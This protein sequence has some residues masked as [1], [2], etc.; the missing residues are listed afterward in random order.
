MTTTIIQGDLNGK[1]FCLSVDSEAIATI[2]ELFSANF[3]FP[4]T[5]P[6][7]YK[8]P[9]DSL[10]PNPLKGIRNSE[11]PLPGG[12][13]A[14]PG[15]SD[16]GENGDDATGAAAAK[17]QVT[18]DVD[19][20]L[21]VYR[22]LWLKTVSRPSARDTDRRSL[23]RRML[24]NGWT[25]DEL[26]RAI[27]GHRHNTFFLGDNDRATQYRTLKLFIGSADR[28]ERGL[29]LA[30]E[31]Q[32]STYP[33]MDHATVIN[34]LAPMMPAGFDTFAARWHQKNPDAKPVQRRWAL[35][36]SIHRLCDKYG[37]ESVAAAF[38]Q[39]ERRGIGNVGY[40]AKV[41]ETFAQNRAATDL[42]YRKES[43]AERDSR[44]A[45]QADRVYRELGLA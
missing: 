2:A 45:E 8:K 1:P 21:D 3:H 10:V 17:A 13:S 28:I 23:V 39:C 6:F 42:G 35:Y 31:Y 38:A 27:S 14:V 15:S 11:S 22:S 44:A 20:V 19:R 24:K 9:T 16:D 37:S 12:G 36:E 30:D 40:V 43:P 32:G 26:C 7:I 5:P 41:A 18:K 33:S 4:P 25:A 34:E 29:E